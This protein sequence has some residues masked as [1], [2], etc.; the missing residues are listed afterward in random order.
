MDS[1]RCDIEVLIPTFQRAELLRRAIKSVQAQTYSALSICVYDNASTDETQAM[2]A[3]LAL[4][5]PRIKYFRHDENVGAIGNFNFALSKVTAPYFAFL[6]DDDVLFPDWIL[7]A[8]SLLNSHSNIACW[9]GNTLQ[10]DDSTGRV[11]RGAGWLYRSENVVYSPFEA[12]ARICGGNHME[13]QGLVFRTAMVRESGVRFHDDVGLADVDFEL[14]IAGRYGVGMSSNLSAAMSIHVGS[15][16][17]GARPFSLY[18][19]AME[20]IG[21][22]LLSSTALSEDQKRRCTNAW[23]MTVILLLV[24][25]A[26]LWVENHK[27][28]EFSF[29]AGI[30]KER[31][32]NKC[33]SFFCRVILGLYS[34]PLPTPYFAWLLLKLIHFFVRP[35]AYVSRFLPMFRRKGS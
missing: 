6:S 21:Q 16:S 35:M 33:I 23:E 7:E 12:C 9:G 30:L 31:Y 22:R 15:A 11:R 26:P 24:N 3:Q 25:Y 13:F 4:E 1:A 18:W 34:L 5:D 28:T 10:V 29:I 32:P 8:V 17:S 19:P 14:A 20:I 2:V 27:A